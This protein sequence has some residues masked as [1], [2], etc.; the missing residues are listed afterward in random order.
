LKEAGGGCHI[1]ETCLNDGWL[2]E[3]LE[4]D[5]VQSGSVTYPI[6]DQVVDVAYINLNSAGTGPFMVFF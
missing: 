5:S 2:P 3:H 1:G 6:S 4:Y